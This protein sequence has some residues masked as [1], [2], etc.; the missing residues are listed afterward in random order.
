LPGWGIAK[1]VGLAAFDIRHAVSASGTYNL[2]VGKGRQFMGSGSNR[3][4]EFLIGNWSTNW[5]LTLDTGTPVTVNC[6]TSTGADNG[7]FA[8]LS[9]VSPY[10]GAHN[11]QQYYNPAAFATPPVVT[12]VGQSNY[13]PLGGGNT[14]V[15][16]PPL[17]RLDFSLFKAFPVN[18]RMRFEFRAEVFNLSNTPAFS[19][20]G[21]LN[22]LNTT[23]FAQI[24]STRDSPNDPREIQLA[25]KFYF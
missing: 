20:P 7:C 14:Q 12:Q 21:S 1:D 11:V 3:V 4:A 13:A 15:T 18:E 23:T 22:Y 9:G 6:A 10:S 17:H 24:T 5:I 16:G 2:P 25:L 19:S 8:L